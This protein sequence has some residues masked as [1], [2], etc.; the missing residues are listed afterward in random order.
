[1]RPA[2]LSLIDAPQSVCQAPAFTAR[3]PSYPD[4]AV[5]LFG[6]TRN[7]LYGNSSPNS[8]PNPNPLEL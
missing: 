4:F 2:A 1:M 8:T 5:R 6:Q 7:R 3:M